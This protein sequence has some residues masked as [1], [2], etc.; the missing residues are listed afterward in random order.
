MSTLNYNSSVPNNAS[1]F[2]VVLSVHDI[3]KHLQLCDTDHRCYTTPM[4]SSDVKVTSSVTR[5]VCYLHM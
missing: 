5:V 1:N 4:I 2:K 3:L